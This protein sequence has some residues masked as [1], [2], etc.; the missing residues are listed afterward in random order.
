MPYHAMP[1]RANAIEHDQL[2]LLV[3][4]TLL[5]LQ[6]VMLTVAGTTSECC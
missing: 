4:L 3:V 1:C 2:V 6:L 5:Q